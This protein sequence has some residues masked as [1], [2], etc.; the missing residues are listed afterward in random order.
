MAD[1]SQP[2]IFFYS[3][4]LVYAIILDRILLFFSQSNKK[5]PLS[6]DGKKFFFGRNWNLRIHIWV[7]TRDHLKAFKITKIS[8]INVSQILKYFNILS[9]V[10]EVQHPTMNH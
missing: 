1:F 7:C 6:N 9:M 4:L 10:I 3:I 5:L 2:S 8:K